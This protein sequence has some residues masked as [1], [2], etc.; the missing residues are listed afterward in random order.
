MLNNFRVAMSTAICDMQVAVKVITIYVVAT[1][2]L[3]RASY[4]VGLSGKE[5][6]IVVL[7]CQRAIYKK[8]PEL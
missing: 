5:E 7:V 8:T 2:C 3:A 4:L 6:G 1:E